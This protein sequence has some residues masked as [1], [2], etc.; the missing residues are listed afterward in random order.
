MID[1]HDLIRDFQF[2]KVALT[3]DEKSDMANKRERNLARARTGL[4]KL[5][6]PT[7]VETINQGGKAMDTM[8]HPPEG[9]E[10]SRYDIDLGVVFEEGDA[11]TPYTTRKWIADAIGEAKPANMVNDPDLKQKCVRVTYSDGYQCDFPVFRRISQDDDF[12]YEI[13]IGTEWLASNPQDVNR[14]FR[15][16]VKEK[17]P[18]EDG[19][20]QLRRIVRL[21]KFF[22]KVRASKTQ[23]KFPA[24]LLMTA[25]T[26]NN[27]VPVAGRDDEAFYQT[28][29]AIRDSLSWSKTVYI[30]SLQITDSKDSDRLDRFKDAASKAIGDLKLVAE[31]N[32]DLSEEDVC[33]AW[34]KIFS[35]SYFDNFAAQDKVKLS[36]SQV[37][38][39]SATGGS[40]LLLG[41][42]AV[43]AVA[44]AVKNSGARD[45]GEFKPRAAVNKR[46]GGTSA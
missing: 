33:K 4:E 28:L 8:T 21:M 12:K 19:D 22:A 27:Y 2:S 36:E 26:A 32:K 3:A 39:K 11:L 7:I 34:K 14:W 45:N 16:E 18:E 46:G 41:A 1:S 25:L 15:D 24:G 5:S 42:L 10:I 20:Y 40:G 35:H 43:G 31:N 38:D 44:A 23:R 9:D 6:K 29:L 37:G 30:D 13:S 17:S